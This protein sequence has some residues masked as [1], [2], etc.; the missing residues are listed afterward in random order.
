M[1]AFPDPSNSPA[2]HTRSLRIGAPSIAISTSAG[3]HATWIRSFCHV[4]RLT[5]YTTADA[6]RSQISLTQLHGL[7]PI[8][9]SLAFIPSTTLPSEALNLAC[10]F[11]F[12]KDLSLYSNT[13]DGL[14]DEWTPPSISPKFTG[15]LMLVTGNGIQP[16]ARRLLDLPGGLHFSGISI[17]CPDRCS[18]DS[19][20]SVGMFRDPGI[21]LHLL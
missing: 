2:H 12:L 1:R 4:I 16:Y 14:G 8:L 5:V 19:R 6:T 17:R 9:E 18:D 21:S 15:T 10:S 11:P 7:S 20:V 3:A 13:E